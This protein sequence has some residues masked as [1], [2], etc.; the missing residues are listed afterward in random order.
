MNKKKHLNKN[1]L[2]KIINL[3]TSLNKGLSDKLKLHFPNYIK[4]KKPNSNFI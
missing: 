1:N 4:I 2:I 3:K